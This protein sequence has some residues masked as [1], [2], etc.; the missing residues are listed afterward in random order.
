MGN[1]KQGKAIGKHA[2]I[3]VNNEI[4]KTDYWFLFLNIIYKFK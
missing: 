1:Y 4:I 3:T 2:L